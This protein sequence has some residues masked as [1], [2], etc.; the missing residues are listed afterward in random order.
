MSNNNIGSEIVDIGQK[1]NDGIVNINSSNEDNAK[2]SGYNTNENSN[3]SGQARVNSARYRNA[4]PAEITISPSIFSESLG[5]LDDLDLLDSASTIYFPKAHQRSHH[6]IQ[7][8]GQQLES[9]Q[10]RLLEQQRQQRLFLSR[11]QQSN[12]ISQPNNFYNSGQQFPQANGY[13]NQMNH[14]HSPMPYSSYSNP[15]YSGHQQIVSQPTSSLNS[16]S[17]ASSSANNLGLNFLRQLNATKELKMKQ[18][19]D[20]C[21]CILQCQG[22]VRFNIFDQNDSL[23]FVASEKSNAIIRCLCSSSRPLVLSLNDTSSRSMLLLERT[24]DCSFLCGLLCPDKVWVK[25]PN[26]QLIGYV[27]QDFAIW[28][29]Y[30]MYNILRQPVMN[31][32]G[33]LFDCTFCPGQNVEFKIKDRAKRDIGRIV[34]EWNNCGRELFTT[35]D[36]FRITLSADLESY[37]KALCIGALF[38]INFRQYD[39][40]FWSRIRLGFMVFLLI[41]IFHYR[42]NYL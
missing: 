3:I 10:Q 33:S 37:D 18:D 2:S 34:K 32:S 27:Q 5:D 17:D 1:N 16:V 24:L 19:I 11:Q 13:Y 22:E 31:V 14:V 36:N 7:F 26:G 28:S 35:V 6:E 29:S 4:L 15:N 12:Q 38:M 23:Q 41:N 21:S 25:M 20:I 39:L 42:Y 9:Q 40:T 30:T 8:S